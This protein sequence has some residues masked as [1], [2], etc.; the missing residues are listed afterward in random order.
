MFNK[1]FSRTFWLPT[2]H[3]ISL[4]D[5]AVSNCGVRSPNCVYTQQLGDWIPQ[6]R[7]PILPERGIQL[8][9]FDPANGSIHLAFTL[10]VKQTSIHLA[11]FDPPRI[12]LAGSSVNAV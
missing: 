2:I 8:G 9:G 4:P 6:L 7:G 1:Q 3:C 11:D 5:V 10:A 12:P